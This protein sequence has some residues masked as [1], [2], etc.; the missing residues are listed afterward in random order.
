LR[1]QPK[2]RKFNKE[3]SDHS[4]NGNRG[5]GSTILRIAK[6]TEIQQ[7]TKWPFQQRQRGGGANHYGNSQT[8]GNWL[9]RTTDNV[10]GGK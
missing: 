3:Q 6:A 8:A 5:G 10:L 4:S 9:K 7:G 1:E 2:F